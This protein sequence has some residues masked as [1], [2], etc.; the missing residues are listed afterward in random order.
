MRTLIVE[1]Q[2]MIRDV[3]QRACERDFGCELAGVC[4]S[5]AAALARLAAG[6]VDL[7]L[8]DLQLPDGDGLDLLPAI[9]T[10]QPAARILVLSSR[11]DPLAVY[12]IDR[13]H[14]SGFIDK[15]SQTVELLGRALAAIAAGG[16]YFSPAF[17]AERLKRLNDPQSFDKILSDREQ[18]VLLALADCG[19]DH[20][21]ARQ[22]GISVATAEKHRF[23]LMRKL[24]LKSP[25]ALLRYARA[26]GFAAGH[27]PD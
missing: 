9:R 10:R 18:T 5:G 13:A 24:G 17:L 22:L 7:V 12:R 14:L 16:V 26:Q 3:L 27:L 19:D 2:A 4:A 6:P 8:L 21:V 11:C 15:G 23:N 1:D 20:H 25:A